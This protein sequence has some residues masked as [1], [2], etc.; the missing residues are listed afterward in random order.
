MT[1]NFSGQTVV[2]GRIIISQGAAPPVPPS[3]AVG[4][5]TETGGVI[6]GVTITDGGTGYVFPPYVFFVDATSGTGGTGTATISGGIVTGVTIDT[7]GT[8]YTSD[9]EISFSPPGAQIFRA[10]DQTNNNAFGA[11]VA[12]NSDGSIM[13][14]GAHGADSYDGAIYVYTGTTWQNEQKLTQTGDNSYFGWSVGI[15]DDGSTII[16]GAVYGFGNA[17]PVDQTGRISV[18]RGG[19]TS[20][21]EVAI[22]NSKAETGYSAYIGYAIDLT[23]DGDIVVAGAFARNAVYVWHSD[24]AAWDDFVQINDPN[25]G[26]NNFGK[27]VAITPDAQFIVVGS[28]YM[29]RPDTDFTGTVQIMKETSPGSRSWAQVGSNIYPAGDDVQ[30]NY[31]EYFGTSVTCSDDGSTIAVGTPYYYDANNNAS[32]AVYIYEQINSTTWSEVQILTPASPA[33]DNYFFGVNVSISA[34]GSKIV[35]GSGYLGYDYGGPNYIY[36]VGGAYVLTKTGGS[37]AGA[38]TTELFTPWEI[39]EGTLLGGYAT[40]RKYLNGVAMSPDGN[41]IAAGAAE[42]NQGPNRPGST[43]IFPLD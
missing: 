33:D 34:D 3:V 4:N 41:Y 6:T 25:G 24:N 37:W 13:V 12:L 15:S 23:T 5:V 8:G 29:E 2:S 27:S 9:V 38:Y 11:N 30:G 22:L 32:G 36:E 1:I 20:W 18:F 14:A 42:W 28:T 40:Y 43:Y 10:S 19:G 39:R 16:A 7:G 26:G 21:S 17:A 31:P 35:M